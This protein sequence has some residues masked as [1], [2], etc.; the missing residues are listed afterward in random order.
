MQNAEET[1]SE[2]NFVRCNSLW[3]VNSLLVLLLKR[4]KINKYYDYF[5]F[6]CVQSRNYYLV[7]QK[8][9]L[10]KVLAKRNFK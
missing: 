10:H 2:E 3:N 8:S 7:P 4:T 6:N 9:C 5:L 1:I